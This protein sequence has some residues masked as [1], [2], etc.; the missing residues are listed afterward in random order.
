MWNL[1]LLYL[2]VLAVSVSAHRSRSNA[3]AFYSNNKYIMELT[4]STFH[5]YVYG[6]N[7]ST[8][9]EFYAPWCG[10]CKQLKPEFETAAKKAHDYAQF[11][12]VNCDD[13]K[14]KQF[15]ASQNINAF[16]TLITYRPPKSFRETVPRD[17]QYA[18]Q[19]F[20]NER[21]A[22]SIINIMRGTLKSH[23]KKVPSTKIESY[24]TRKTGKPRALL[25]TDKA[26]VSALYKSLAVDFLSVMD[27]NY[28]LVKDDLVDQIR[29][30]APD[31]ADDVP[32]LLVIQEDGT[33]TH[34]SGKFSKRAISEFLSEF[35]V[36]V[37]GDFSD[38]KR[39]IDGI[40]NGK[41]KSFLQYK[42]KM[43]KKE[44]KQSRDKLGKDEL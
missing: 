11:A 44:E 30:Y 36:P 8:I 31:L 5:D 22:N 21:K 12:A 9:V 41:F 28:I 33:V 40:K 1:H 3:P 29:K 43:A 38:R 2:I 6:S 37:E 42:K 26:Q 25:L 32:Q 14:N 19:P 13:E 17:Q 24:F 39:A 16:P 10:Y 4:S 35:A 23:V 7:Y 34:Y 20:E 15:C 18:V 27:L